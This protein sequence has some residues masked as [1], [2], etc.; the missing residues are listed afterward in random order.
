MTSRIS[1]G[2]TGAKKSEGIVGLGRYCLKS[3]S[4]LGIKA[5]TFSPI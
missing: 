1:P 2:L 4:L 5:E 3:I